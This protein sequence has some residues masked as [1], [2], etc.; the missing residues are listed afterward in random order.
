MDTAFTEEAR[1]RWPGYQIIG[2]G[3][4]AVIYHC[5]RKIELCTMPMIAG[6]IVAE[7][8]GPFCS[9]VRNENGGWHEVK[10]IELPRPRLIATIRDW[11]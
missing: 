2:D 6:V 8:C 4:L 11:E 5:A 1:K 10:R 7:S 3:S 9:H